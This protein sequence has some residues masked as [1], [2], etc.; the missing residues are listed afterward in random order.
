MKASSAAAPRNSVWAAAAP[1]VCAV[2]CL[3]APLVAV[4]LPA[5]SPH[6]PVEVAFKGATALAAAAFLWH[7]LSVHGRR[8]VIVPVA[9]GLAAWAATALAGLAGTPEAA[10][11]AAGGLLMAAGL[12]WNA[13][14]RHEAA[15]H[16]CGCP[17]HDHG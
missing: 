9:L 14:L 8:R 7:G 10:A 17:A 16:R 13:R 11:S 5:A 12:F 1:L 15:C 3:A 6:G 2:H 4:A